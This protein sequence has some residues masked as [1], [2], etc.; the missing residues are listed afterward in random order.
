[1]FVVTVTFR[2]KSGY[3]KAFRERIRD[4]ARRSLSDEVG[5][6]QFDVCENI[7]GT[8]ELFL[9]ELYADKAAFDAHKASV[10]FRAFDEATASMV[11][12]KQVACWER[13]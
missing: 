5:C 4:N 6:H 10:H 7:E 1:M 2:I 13:L 9:Y 8:G 11:A 12:D 3:E